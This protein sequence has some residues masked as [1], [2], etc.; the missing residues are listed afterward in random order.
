MPFP[1][2]LLAFAAYVAGSAN[3]AI[4]LLKMVGKPDPRLFSSKNPGVVNVYRQEGP[5]W[6]G[7]VL[8]L[9]IGRAVAVALAARYLLDG[10]FV[11][12][13]GLFLVVGNRYPVF[14]RFRGGKGVA[15]YLGFTLALVP[16]WAIVSMP[17]W[18]ITHRLTRTPFIGSFVMIGL[19]ATG[20]LVQSGGSMLEA[21]GT[22]A[23]IALIVHGHG[24]NMRQWRSG[25]RSSV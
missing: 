17:A 23:T 7:I 16:I 19:L 8:V 5:V 9:E 1:E 22:F 14:H 10:R 24:S 11:A 6:A 13:I 25:L 12:W 2:I 20:M 18:L 15:A 21:L 4:V 3:M